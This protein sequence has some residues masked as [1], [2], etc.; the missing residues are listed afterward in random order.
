MSSRWASALKGQ[1]SIHTLGEKASAAKGLLAVKAHK[2]VDVPL[3]IQ[4]LQAGLQRQSVSSRLC[5]TRMARVYISNGLVTTSTFRAVYF[6]K[7][8][9]AE[10]HPS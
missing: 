2:A 1:E 9:G 7:T 5:A 6:S 3:F 8:R 10:G 4:C